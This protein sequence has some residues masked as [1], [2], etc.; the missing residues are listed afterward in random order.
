MTF[1]C[2]YCG[3][4]TK[5]LL[6][7]FGFGRAKCDACERRFLYMPMPIKEED[8][9]TWEH[10]KDDELGSRLFIVILIIAVVLAVYGSFIGISYLIS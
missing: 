1:T 8:R 4:Q 3:A 2:P 5:T 7:N 9:L 6:G 10:Y